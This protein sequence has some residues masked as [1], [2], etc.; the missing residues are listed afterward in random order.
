[1]QI[2]FTFSPLSAHVGGSGEAVEKKHAASLQ[3][4]KVLFKHQIKNGYKFNGW[5]A[6]L[7]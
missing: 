2:S 7:D 3:K 1:M 6:N 5:G 4:L